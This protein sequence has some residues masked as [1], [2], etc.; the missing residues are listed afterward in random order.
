MPLRR[1]ND[2]LP[3]N[4]V[5]VTGLGVCAAP[6]KNAA[7]FAAGNHFRL[8]SAADFAGG[9]TSFTLPALTATNLYWNT[10]RLNVDGSLWV[11]SRAAP[12]IAQTSLAGGDLI[13]SGGDGTPGWTYYVLSSTNLTLPLAQWTRVATNQFDANGNFIFTNEINLNAA[14]AFYR[15]QSQ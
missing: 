10:G 1:T 14:D 12:D 3:M 6:G 15:M 8:F 4:R 13:L 5:V 7:D 11:M 2:G 9:F